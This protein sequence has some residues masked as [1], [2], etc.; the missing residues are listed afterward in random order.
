MGRSEEETFKVKEKHVELD[1]RKINEIMEKLEHLTQ[2]VDLITDYLIDIS[3]ANEQWKL[4][5]CYPYRF[6]AR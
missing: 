6:K 1:K 4:V 3:P 2:Q 5:R